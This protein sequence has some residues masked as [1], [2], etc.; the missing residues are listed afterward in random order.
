MAKKKEAK[1]PDDAPRTCVFCK[2]FRIDEGWAGYGEYTPGNASSMRCTKGKF[3]E[4]LG[5][6]YELDFKVCLTKAATCNQ[7]QQE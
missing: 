5:L 4:D 6:V 1:H 7:Y 2:H 3:N